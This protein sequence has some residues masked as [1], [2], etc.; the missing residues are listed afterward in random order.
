MSYRT[1]LQRLEESLGASTDDCC[2]CPKRIL[3]V[4]DQESIPDENK[5]PCPVQCSC[6]RGRIQIINFNLGKREEAKTI[7]EQGS[8]NGEPD[9]PMGGEQA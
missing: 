7:G 4:I 3:I 8:M 2:P 9:R 5:R 1:R 6:H